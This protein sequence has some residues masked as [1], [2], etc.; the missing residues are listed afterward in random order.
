MILQS[1]DVLLTHSPGW[2]AELIRLGAALA[3]KPNLSNHV[4][5]MHHYD[6]KGVPWGIEGRPGGVGW[7]DMRPY[8]GSPWTIDNC[9][10]PGRPDDTRHAAASAAEGMLGTPY[11]WAAILGDGFDDVHVKLWNLRFADGKPPGHVVCS[12]F[13]AFVYAKAG[14]DH[15]AFE[16]DDRLVQP[17]DW[18]DFI[19][20]H[21]YNIGLR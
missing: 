5:F 6:S 21:G 9:G 16:A 17:A 3:G 2:T 7:V 1:G 20:S 11:D 10:Q 18:A 19:I 15:P 4:A 8:I 14:W 12:S 13:A